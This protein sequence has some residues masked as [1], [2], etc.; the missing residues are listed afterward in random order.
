MR[1]KDESKINILP[2]KIEPNHIEIF[3]D[4]NIRVYKA[5]LNPGQETLYHSH[6]V[7]TLYTVIKGGR[8]KTINHSLNEGCP[9][10]VVSKQKISY[11]IKLLLEKTL[12]KPLTLIEGF[13]FFMPSSKKAV[14]HK[15]IASKS[16]KE[17]MVLISIEFKN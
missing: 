10:R 13:S 2:V 9:T 6:T 3:E 15:A 11:K 4:S 14:Y 7:D 17:S 8:I 5:T 1:I 12:N 16:N